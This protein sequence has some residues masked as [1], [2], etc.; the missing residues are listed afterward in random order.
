MGSII[1]CHKKKAKRPYEISRINRRVYTIEELCYYLCNH[2]YLIAA[3]EK[4]LA[5]I[6]S[7]TEKIN[8]KKITFLL[9]PHLETEN[10]INVSVKL[11]D[12]TSSFNLKF[13]YLFSEELSCDKKLG[14]IEINSNNPLLSIGFSDAI[15]TENTEFL[16]PDNCK[17]SIYGRY[18]DILPLRDLRKVSEL[19]Y[20]DSDLCDDF[21]STW[22]EFETYGDFVDQIKDTHEKTLVK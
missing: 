14:N 20:Y 6:C 13:G 10:D 15:I 7:L 16:V 17:V 22:P 11:N 21:K 3:D 18:T 12:N 5:K 2:L 4:E 1:L 9:N 8:A 19:Y